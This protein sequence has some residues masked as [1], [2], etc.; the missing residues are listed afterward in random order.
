MTPLE[1]IET[2]RQAIPGSIQ[3]KD[4]CTSAVSDLILA[5]GKDKVAFEILASL[6]P[7]SR[8]DD[9]EV[10]AAAHLLDAIV[11]PPLGAPVPTEEAPLDPPTPPSEPT[12]PALSGSQPGDPAPTT[13]EDEAPVGESKNKEAEEEV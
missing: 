2:L 4:V 8:Q 7:A 1:A 12:D 13:F 10:A 5:N 9:P 3:R 11:N 6:V